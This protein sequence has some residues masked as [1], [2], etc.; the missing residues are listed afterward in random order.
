MRALG[1]SPAITAPVARLIRVGGQSGG[2]QGLG[3]R[4]Q[5]IGAELLAVGD[6]D[7]L[8]QV[9]HGDPVADMGDGGQVVANEQITH[10]QILLQMLQQA[11]NLRSDRYI[12]RRHR[13][14]EDNE[15]AVAR[16]GP[17]RWRHAGAARR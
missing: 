7:D 9:H 13:L 17:G 1:T 16:P 10:P 11:N 6:L 5:R 14:I 15:P 3:V 12:Q 4:M 2:K 8:P